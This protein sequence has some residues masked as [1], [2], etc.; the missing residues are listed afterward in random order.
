MVTRG[1]R[2]RRIQLEFRI[3]IYTQLYIKQIINKD[4]LYRTVN[5]TQP[6]TYKGKNLKKNRIYIHIFIYEYIYMNH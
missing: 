3:N 4:L 1:G 6:L 5:Y 2:E